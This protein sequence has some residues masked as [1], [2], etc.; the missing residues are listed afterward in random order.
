MTTMAGRYLHRVPGLYPAANRGHVS[1]WSLAA[2]TVI[3]LVA[4]LALL[5]LNA[6]LVSTSRMGFY[7]VL[8]VAVV[9]YA[10]TGEHDQ[11]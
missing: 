8:A 11:R 4:A 5:A 7:A 6:D 1:A 2:C 9:A 10:A 3:D